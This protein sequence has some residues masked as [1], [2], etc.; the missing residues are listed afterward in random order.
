MNFQEQLVWM[1][2]SHVASVYPK[3]SLR[4]EW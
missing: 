1:D 2:G 3:P 4:L